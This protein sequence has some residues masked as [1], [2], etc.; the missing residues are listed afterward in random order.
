MIGI[1]VDIVEMQY[2]GDILQRSG[3]VFVQRVY[4][5]AEI[6]SA[7]R[8][9]NRIGF[10]GGNFAAKE[11]LFKALTLNWAFDIDLRQIETLRGSHGEPVMRLSGIVAKIAEGKGLQKIT[12]SMSFN[13]SMA[14]AIVLV[15]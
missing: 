9:P 5:D 4:S 11:A 14:I 15:E 3:D 10:Y 1:G 12:V 8:S 7:E 2:M 6:Q 13:Y